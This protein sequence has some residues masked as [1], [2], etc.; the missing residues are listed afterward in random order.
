MKCWK[1]W[2]CSCTRIEHKVYGLSKNG[3]KQETSEES[4]MYAW[5]ATW[6]GIIA[7]QYLWEWSAMYRTER[8]V[9]YAACASSLIERA[10]KE[11]W[12]LS[13]M[14]ARTHNCK[15]QLAHKNGFGPQDGKIDRARLY[16]FSMRLHFSIAH[17]SEP[18][19]DA[20][21]KGK[22]SV[23]SCCGLWILRFRIILLLSNYVSM[24]SVRFASLDAQFL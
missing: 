17:I 1:I 23:G 14:L 19:N 11:S 22:K 4:V 24:C 18:L 13:K 15:G 6:R 10:M 3:L 12:G 5:D 7:W 16:V 8:L 20:K 9:F 2:E 21:F